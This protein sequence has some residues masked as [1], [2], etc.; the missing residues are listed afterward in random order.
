MRKLFFIAILALLAGSP[1]MYQTA[2]AQFDPFDKICSTNPTDAQGN[3]SS[4]CQDDGT[5]PI[6]GR[7]KEGV[8]IKA[9]NIISLVTGVTAV[10]MMITGGTLLVLSTGDPAK[11]SKARNTIIYAAVGVAITV[12]AQSVVRFLLRRL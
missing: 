9:I 2:N 3:P 12:I 5:D 7:D 11:V 1:F 6:T 10:I 8:L 4:V